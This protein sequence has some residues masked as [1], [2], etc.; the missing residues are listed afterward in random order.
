MTTLNDSRISFLDEENLHLEGMRP[1]SKNA[2][3]VDKL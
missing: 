2:E 1:H 3:T